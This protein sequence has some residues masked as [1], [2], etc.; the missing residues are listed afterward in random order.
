MKPFWPLLC[1]TLL[2]P[3]ALP[4]QQLPSVVPAPAL[5]EPASSTLTAAQLEQLLGPIALY[6][7]A[8]IAL[9][10]PA[11]TAPADV[12]LAARYLNDRGNDLSQV[13]QRAWDDSVK[14]LTNYP[15][16]LKWMDE[17]L[18]WTKQVG[19]AFAEQPA[20]V[21]NAIQ[22][23]R[24]QARAAGTLVDTP[25]QQV[26]AEQTVIRI[27]PADPEVIY[28]PYYDPAVVF[29]SYPVFYNRPLFTYGP[30]RRVG[31]W[32]AC[33]FDWNHRTLWVG[34]R[35]R[36][37]QG[38][39]DW[40]QP[41][42]PIVAAVPSVRVHAYTSTAFRPAQPW[43]PPVR[44]TRVTSTSYTRS[45]YPTVAAPAP[46]GATPGQQRPGNGPG[47]RSVENT[48]VIP[49]VQPLN[50]VAAPA[51]IS[52]PVPAPTL[53]NAP[54]I[55]AVP[56]IAA[57]PLGYRSQTPDS[58]RPTVNR[59]RSYQGP[60]AAPVMPAAPLHVTP[61][62]TRGAQSPAPSYPTVV[63]PQVDRGASSR[64]AA[65]VQAGSLQRVSPTPQAPATEPSGPAPAASSSSPNSQPRSQASRQQRGRRALD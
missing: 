58:A 33:D 53:S 41:I 42:I 26:L 54:T 38:R 7:D 11:A 8:L 13:E 28:V 16:I 24:A 18:P 59:S 30:G 63:A 55:A 23:L 4:A 57:Q 36:Q 1:V 17:N 37:W 12:V 15:D 65:P 45:A 35:R 5:A 56:P 20:E 43:R 2:A 46:I 39:H 14:S 47:Y 48:R 19:E 29:V 50:R 32:L 61:S 49:R 40:R 27:V 3:S 52:Q 31:S 34:D 6:P 25:Q 62:A 22:R 9:I 44:T 51:E 10:L 60:A 64:A 21:M